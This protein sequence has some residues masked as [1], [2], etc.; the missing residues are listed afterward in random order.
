MIFTLRHTLL[1]QESISF[2]GGILKITLHYLYYCFA[3]QFVAIFGFGKK[4]Q[5]LK[6]SMSFCWK[7][8]VKSCTH[9]THSTWLMTCLKWLDITVII[10]S[11]GSSES[12]DFSIWQAEHQ[13]HHLPRQRVLL[14][15]QNTAWKLVS[16]GVSDLWQSAF[17]VPPVPTTPS[18]VS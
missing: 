15:F 6:H 5:C 10:L 8:K 4:Q 11:E 17:T 1:S 7:K 18:C 3:F 13:A 9:W 2:L 16:L 14:C 12:L